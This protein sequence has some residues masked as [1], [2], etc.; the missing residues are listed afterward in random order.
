MIKVGEIQFRLA[1]E[2]DVFSL[3]R[4]YQVGKHPSNSDPVFLDAE[5]LRESIRSPF[6]AWILGEKNGV[7]LTVFS[8]L[9][10]LENRL[11]KVVR[12]YLDPVVTD[13]AGVLKKGL[14]PLLAYL[15]DPKRKIEVIYTTA[16]GVSLKQ[17][18]ATLELGFKIVGVLPM[19]SA[20][21]GNRLN[22]VAAYFFDKVLEE[23]RHQ[24]FQLHPAIAPFFDLVKRECH[25][26][27]LP[28]A[29]D[30]PSS[31]VPFEAVPSLELIHAPQFVLRRFSKLEERKSLAM[32]FYP[33]TRPNAMI[34]DRDESV[35]IYVKL[36]PE[37]QMATIIGERLEKAVNPTELYSQLARMLAREKISYIEVI[38]DAA[39]LWGIDCF[40]KAGYLP[41]TYFPAL[42]AQGEKRRDYVVLARSSERL[43]TNSGLP[44]SVNKIYLEYLAEYYKLEGRDYLSKFK[45][46]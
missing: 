20:T 5:K 2:T 43:F 45:A 12:L 17:Q 13:W 10:D 29:Q 9:I 11:A 37:E 3:M 1:S 23:K 22:G 40:V 39:D 14:V 36:I 28:V 8:I 27:D 41:C 42:K 6:T 26:E 31:P 15:K 18:E 24:D 19:A 16:Q 44:I 33:F 4:L 34:I 32:H 38:N 35:E 7:A 25:L 30:V 21:E 46:K